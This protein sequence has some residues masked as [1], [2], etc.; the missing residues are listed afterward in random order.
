[1]GDLKHFHTTSGK[2]LSVIHEPTTSFITCEYRP[3][4]RAFLTGAYDGIVRIHDE[5]TRKVVVN[6]KGGGLGLPGQINRILCAKYVPEDPN[7][8]VSGGWDGTVCIWD[9]RTARCSHK[10]AGLNI[11][12]D[13]IDIHDGII[14][15]G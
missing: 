12:G 14:L 8:I 3:D 15:T 9:V 6:L 1:M 5:H 10:I 11:C 4:G 7:I 2:T 13:S